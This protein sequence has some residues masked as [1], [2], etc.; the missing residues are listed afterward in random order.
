[1]METG[2]T[3]KTEQHMITAT[4]NTGTKSAA[5]ELESRIK[6]SGWIGAIRKKIPDMTAMHQSLSC[7]VLVGNLKQDDLFKS[8]D[9]MATLE[10]LTNRCINGTIAWSV[11]ANKLGPLAS[12]IVEGKFREI[13]GL[14]EV[15]PSI[16]TSNPIAPTPVEAVIENEPETETVPDPVPVAVALGTIDT[17]NGTKVKHGIK[18]PRM[19]APSFEPTVEPIAKP[20]DPMSVMAESIGKYLE[21]SIM[22]AIKAC[23]ARAIL[24]V[25]PALDA[26]AEAVEGID[27][28]VTAMPGRALSVEQVKP[29]DVARAVNEQFNSRADGELRKLM[30]GVAPSMFSEVLS[31]A[32]DAVSSVTARPDMEVR[33]TAA[34]QPKVDPA[35]AW[36]KQLTI[37]AQLIEKASDIAPQNAV[38]VGPAGCGKTE[39]AIQF[40]ATYSRFI[41]IMDCANIREAREWFGTKGAANGA[42]Y[43]RKSQFWMAVE[44]GNAVI[45]LDELNRL[46]PHVLNALMPLLD[47]RR[48]SFVEEVGEVLKVGPR[49]VFFATMNEG[50]D[51][52]GTHTMDRAL[53]NRFPRR[54]ELSFLPEDK[55]QT[56]LLDKIPGL[57]KPDAENLVS[58]ANTIRA[59]AT[60]FGGG[61][62]ETMST[63]Q[64]IAA[65]QDFVLGG[66]NTFQ[67]TVFNHFTAEGGNDSERAQV[68]NMFQLKGYTF[69]D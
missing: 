43:F 11:F 50:L 21:P 59:K 55:E 37:M 40:A 10:T 65:A 47:H 5:E 53:K 22:H 12:H 23:E 17:V 27:R 1:M 41:M 28:R 15:N 51:Y 64:L 42:T 69:A 62:S 44:K 52:S 14:I 34:Y 9:L 66:T 3:Q 29:E 68:I 49:T 63:R 46:S 8:Q 7:T 16:P 26:V 4:L 38:L 67:S 35:Y 13:L 24:H 39:L 18:V 6:C 60:G 20:G 57:S 32:A 33:L 25:K 45:L 54:I 61:L 36:T 56:V 31:K 19:E 2:A 30:Q 58:L 48:Q